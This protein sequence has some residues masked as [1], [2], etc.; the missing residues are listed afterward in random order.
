MIFTPESYYSITTNKPG[1][2]GSGVVFRATF[3]ARASGNAQIAI[4]ES[5]TLK[6]SN[7]EEIEDPNRIDIAPGLF[8]V[9][10]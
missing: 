4:T 1:V 3:R 2:C 6:T 5:L 9:I 10:E 7:F 8:V